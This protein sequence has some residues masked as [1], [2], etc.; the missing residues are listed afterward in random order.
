MSSFLRILAIPFFINLTVFESI[1]I[2]I[3]FL[4]NCF[5]MTAVV[6]VPDKNIF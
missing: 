1:S 5:A 3:E 6:P 2:E 4:S